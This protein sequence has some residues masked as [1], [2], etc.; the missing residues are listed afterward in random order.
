MKATYNRDDDKKIRQ[1]FPILTDDVAYLDNAAT[2][3]KPIQV[4]DS[5]ADYYSTSN[6]NP[7]RGLYKLSVDATCAYEDSRKA[8]AGFINAQDASSVIFTRNASESLNLIAYSYGMNFLSEGDEILISIMEHHSNLLPWQQ[9]AARAGAVLKY[10]EPNEDFIIT[11]ELLKQNITDRTKIVAITHVSN[12]LGVENDIR[13]FAKIAHDAG[14]LLAVDGAQ[15]VPHIPVDVQDLDCDFLSFSGHKMY[16]PMG[17]GVLYGKTELL[18]KMPPF[19]YGGE[20]IESVTRYDAKYAPL[21]HKFEAGTVNAGGA[22]GLHAAIDYIKGV[23]FDLIRAREDHLTELAFELL[24]QIPGIKILGNKD[25]LMHH[26]IITFTVDGVHPHDVATVMDTDNICVRAGHH[27]AQPLMKYLGVFSTTRASMAFYNT[28]EEV[29]KLAD[30]LSVIRRK[31]G[32][33]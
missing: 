23:G 29:R 14:A 11:P 2:T 1:D 3:Q 16:A 25:P 17:I 13:S 9:V 30:A 26:G 6:S 12:V 18:D 27:C 24:S 22:V 15:S 28:E 21:P 8:V 10:V 7:L 32:Y 20:M 4:L 31:M 33:E 19:L 5:M